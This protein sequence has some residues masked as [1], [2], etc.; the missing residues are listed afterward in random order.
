[1]LRIGFMPSDF[2]PLLLVLGNSEDL[3]FFSKL[4]D[5]FSHTG[6]S[7]ELS[8]IDNV[9]ADIA[10]SL[11]EDS[12]RQGLWKRRDDDR[13][14]DWLLSRSD[15]AHFSAQV[16]ELLQNDNKSGSVMLE[17]GYV[18]ET[19]VKV[20][21]GEYEDTFLVKDDQRGEGLE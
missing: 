9:Y 1:M 6:S 20:S 19:K 3:S 16:K 21:L 7:I 18:N 12:G 10:V 4:L 13:H 15:A 11:T 5:E 8:S 2:H 17:F 14:L